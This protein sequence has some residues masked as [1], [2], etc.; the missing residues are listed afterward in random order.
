[1][2]VNKVPVLSGISASRYVVCAQ[3]LMLSLTLSACEDIRTTGPELNGLPRAMSPSEFVIKSV[4]GNSTGSYSL[5]PASDNGP[6][7]LSRGLNLVGY[8]G[9]SQIVLKSYDTC[10]DTEQEFRPL[11]TDIEYLKDYFDS[12][13]VISADSAVCGVNVL[14]SLFVGSALEKWR[15]ISFRTPYVAIIKGDSV[16]EF[17]GGSG[18]ILSVS[19]TSS[20]KSYGA[21]QRRHDL[22]PFVAHAG[23]QFGGKT[24]T[25]SIDALDTNYDKY[26]LFEI[27][28][29]WTSD[30]KLVCI[31]DWDHSYK[32]SFGLEPSGAK[33]LAEFEELVGSRS[34]VRKCTLQSLASW[35]RD[36]PH[37]KVVTDIKEGNVAGLRAIRE[38]YPDLVSRFIPQIYHP[39]EYFPVRDLGY[40]KI[41]WT[42]YMY[43]GSNSDVLSLIRFMDLYGLTMSKARARTGLPSLAYEATGVKS[44][45][46]TINSDEELQEMTALGAASIYTDFLVEK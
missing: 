45:V 31:H 30:G 33:T 35:M 20:S 14:G 37:S 5:S 17:T 40:E 42:L 28:F 34:A 18:E 22:L 3:A 32:R 38:D 2:F 10:V 43:E 12:F 23:G 29:S 6:L 36:N 16:H 44:W 26:S 9:S 13:A 19:T 24:Y 25:N 8:N 15:S 41:I 21:V 39:D 11:I 46:H 27:D 1:M 7:N 4:G